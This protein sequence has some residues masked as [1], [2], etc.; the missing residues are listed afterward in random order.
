[1]EPKDRVEFAQMILGV[2]EVYEKT[3]TDASI[4]LY[5]SSLIGMTIEEVRQ[6]IARHLGDRDRGRF[7]P[8]PADII[9]AA[10]PKRT[11]VVAWAE[12][13]HAVSKFGRYRSV[14][15]ADEVTNAVVRDLGGW[16]WMCTQNFDEPWTQREFE[17]RY[18]AYRDSG[19]R[20][21]DPLLGIADRENINAGYFDYIKP[22]LLIGDGCV[23]VEE[24]LLLPSQDQVDMRVG[25][26]IKRAMGER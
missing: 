10:A 9:H 26:L 3:P 20:S 14:R 6:G 17:R 18:E 13:E 12:V 23:A 4:E 22:V 24:K 11:P 16:D 1:M 19:V 8:K 25:S 7:M 5:W 21:R 2:A 15:F